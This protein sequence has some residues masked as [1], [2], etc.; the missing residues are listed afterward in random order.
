M[1]EAVKKYL[2]LISLQYSKD[3]PGLREGLDQVLAEEG[4]GPLTNRDTW[5]LHGLSAS[6][7]DAITMQGRQ[8]LESY[9]AL[10]QKLDALF[11]LHQCNIP[12][13]KQTPSPLP[14]A[15]QETLRRI[16]SLKAKTEALP[17]RSL[18]SRPSAV[19]VAAAPSRKPS[20]MTEFPEKILEA[21]KKVS[22]RSRRIAAAVLGTVLLC[23]SII[24][25]LNKPYGRASAD[26][27][28]IFYMDS[29]VLIQRSIYNWKEKY[30]H[31]LLDSEYRELSLKLSNQLLHQEPLFLALSDWDNRLTGPEDFPR[32]EKEWKQYLQLFPSPQYPD[33]EGLRAMIELRRS[34]YVHFQEAA[35]EQAVL[36]VLDS[37][38][39]YPDYAVQFEIFQKDFPSSL[40]L[41]KY[42]HKLE[43]LNLQYLREK[44]F[45]HWNPSQ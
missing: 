39:H 23:L 40:M 13:R 16:H 22:P 35:Q 27:K 44:Q 7:K 24:S 43:E 41:P 11:S 30:R 31:Q 28:K 29:P 25:I 34:N 10:L 18:P 20:F 1:N 3:R 19:P 14:S 17:G 2:A 37:L 9:P 32:L 6:E 5:P 38:H 45:Q 12:D 33:F 26:L 8:A 42:R 36:R 4:E 21:W 15:N